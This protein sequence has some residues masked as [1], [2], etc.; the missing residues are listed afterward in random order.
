M[1]S[2]MNAKIGW[3]LL[4]AFFDCLRFVRYWNYLKQKTIINKETLE[5]VKIP[6]LKFENTHNEIK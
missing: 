4:S 1:V 2:C 5:Y 6:I 3:K